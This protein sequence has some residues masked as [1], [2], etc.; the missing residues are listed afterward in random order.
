MQHLNSGATL[1]NGKYRIES[2]L[3]QGGFGITYLAEQKVTIEG[4][5]GAIEVKIKVTIKE[6]FIKELCDRDSDTRTVSVGSVGSRDLVDRFC[7]KFVKEAHNIAKLQHPNII[8]VLDVFEE[9]GTAYYVMEYIDGGSLAD[10]INQK[11]RLSEEDTLAFTRQIA[12]ALRFI[13][14]QRMNHLDVK[15]ANVLLRKDGTIV[16]ID[17]GLAKNYDEAGEQTTTT[18]MGISAGYAPIEQSRI[19]GV[20]TFSPS[21]D[22]YSLGATMFKMITG[23]TPP[24][25]AVLLDEDLPGFSDCASDRLVEVITKAMSPQRKKRYQSI[26]EFLSALEGKSTLSGQSVVIQ[27]QAAD[28]DAPLFDKEASQ[29]TTT[30]T[31]AQI[32]KFL[33]EDDN[34]EATRLI[35]IE[36]VMKSIISNDELVDL[37]LSVKWCSK[38]LDALDITD[39]GKYYPWST[40]PTHQYDDISQTEFDVASVLTQR[41][42]RMPTHKEFKELIDRCRWS[43]QKYHDVW[44]CKITG[45][46]GKSIFLPAAGKRSNDHITRHNSFGYYWTS[47]AASNRTYA[48][49]LYFNESDYDICAELTLIERSIR[50]VQDF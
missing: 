5:L 28:S 19:G 50:P 11:Q 24:E 20:G 16:L 17:F 4:P 43:W 18:P 34:K 31:S 22:V 14:L 49:Y 8:K 25:A 36:T 37:G 47:T 41:R 23:I 13:H 26:E 27:P 42:L 12:E 6:F 38:N 46:S 39:G 15:P 32:P 30:E 10:L 40:K 2:V 3:G 48:R 35:S 7:Q 44:G 45:P 9:N 33:N 1:Q 29:P 21:T